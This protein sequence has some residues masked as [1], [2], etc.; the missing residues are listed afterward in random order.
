MIPLYALYAPAMWSNPG[1]AYSMSTACSVS[2]Q[3]RCNE[4][5]RL[6]GFDTKFKMREREREREKERK[7]ERK[8][9]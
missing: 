6:Q 8:K 9:R 5:L 4:A 2:D 3:L 7:E 1:A